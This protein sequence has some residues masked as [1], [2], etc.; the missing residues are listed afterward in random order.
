MW[1]P[2]YREGKWGSERSSVLC[3]VTGMEINR[4]WIWASGPCSLPVFHR[5]VLGRG[6]P[7]LSHP[8]PPFLDIFFFII[9]AA[10]GLSCSTWDP[11]LQC[12]GLLSSQARGL[13]GMWAQLHHSMGD[14]SFPTGNRTSVPCI[15]RWILNNWI[16][17]E[18]PMILSI[19][20]FVLWK[21]NL[22]LI[23]PPLIKINI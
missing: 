15:G 16:T 3:A 6:S 21:W 10:S 11:L 13:H 7:H 22:W 18:V 19:A 8:K 2:F 17:G 1:L 20:S 5:A 12:R 14:L 9:L 23:Y 4:A